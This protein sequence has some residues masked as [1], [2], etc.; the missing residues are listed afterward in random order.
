MFNLLKISLHDCCLFSLRKQLLPYHILLSG[1][2]KLSSTYR[3]EE[4]MWCIEENAT[5]Q[6]FVTK[7]ID[8]WGGEVGCMYG[9]LI[10]QE[11]GTC[12][13]QQVYVE[14][15]WEICWI[16]SHINIYLSVQGK[17]HNTRGGGHLNIKNS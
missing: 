16:L 3:F 2:L 8:N 4:P 9:A 15:M 5:F 1:E 17:S 10:S 11:V 12:Y 14:V 13:L 7:N 6:L